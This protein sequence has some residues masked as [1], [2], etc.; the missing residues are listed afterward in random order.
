MD[1]L[2]S[3]VLGGDLDRYNRYQKV[4]YESSIAQGNLCGCADPL[5]Y[6]VPGNVEAR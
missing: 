2:R 4:M 6:D 1:S 5:P 3:R